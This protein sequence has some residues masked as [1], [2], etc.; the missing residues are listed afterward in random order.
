MGYIQLRNY[1]EWYYM[2]YFPSRMFLREKLERKTDDRELV[3]K[4]MND[5]D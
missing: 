4:V 2:K 5:L 1:A 3:E